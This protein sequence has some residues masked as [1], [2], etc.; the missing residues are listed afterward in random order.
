[1]RL[2]DRT[3]LALTMA[4]T[5]AAV[6]AAFLLPLP[7]FAEGAS[8]AG[9]GHEVSQTRAV[10]AFTSIRV[11]GP[12]D[13]HA[14]PGAAGNVTVRAED[15]L[16]PLI[17]TALEGQTLVVRIARHASF[18]TR[19]NLSVD[20]PFA[21]L[22]ALQIRGSGDVSI[23]DLNGP[24]FEASVSGSGDLRVERATLGTLVTD[25]AGSGDMSFSGRADEARYAIAGSGDVHAGGMEAKKVTV[26]ISGSGD[27]EVNATES[28]D[29]S[30][31]GSGDIHYAGHPS[32]VGRHVHGSGDI[33][34]M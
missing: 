30:V 8:V 13:V 11:E 5:A 15:N 2:D 24:R 31:S 25:I 19:R 4:V 16:Q 32:F 17:E 28:L 14:H 26:T 21:Q 18:T 12:V 27:A 7:A 23:D 20:V 9:S 10:G 6:S 33:E 22:S 34:P 29:A 3:H 1:M